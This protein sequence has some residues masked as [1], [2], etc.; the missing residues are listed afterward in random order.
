MSLTTLDALFADESMPV[1]LIKIDVEG[2]EGAVLAGGQQTLIHHRPVLLVEHSADAEGTARLL[3]LT[4]R[5]GYRPFRVVRKRI[6]PYPHPVATS[7]DQAR[8]LLFL[9]GDA[10]AEL[11]HRFS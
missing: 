7:P 2:H 10:H 4:A 6:V 9:H 8:N 5:C 3:A 1:V 11:L